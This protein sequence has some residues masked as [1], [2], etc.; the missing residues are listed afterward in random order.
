MTKR[1]ARQRP[2]FS[3]RLKKARQNISGSLS[4]AMGEV[5]CSQVAAA[6]SMAVTERTV[7]DWIHGVTPVNVERVLASSRLAKA[8]R[9]HL[10]VHDHASA[11]YVARA[12]K[13]TA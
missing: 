6:R 10:C 13:R 1:N 12:R 8:F 5:K 4:R 11:P 2:E 9:Q 7:R 3:A